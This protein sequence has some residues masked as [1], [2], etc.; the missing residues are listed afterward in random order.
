MLAMQYVFPLADDF[1]MAQVRRR[2]AEKGPLFDDYPGLVQKAFLCNDVKGSIL[3]DEVGNS[4]ATFYLWESADAARAFLLGD[5]FRAVS[6]A[7]GRPRVQSWQVIGHRSCGGAAPAFAVQETESLGREADPGAIATRERAALG[8]ALR[9][10]RPGPGLHSISVAFDPYR[11]ELV[12]FSLW[13]EARDA[14]RAL[15]GN[16]RGWEL[17]YLAGPQARPR[18][19]IALGELGRE[20][21][22]FL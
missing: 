19:A 7:F 14:E 5:A 8:E 20:R 3:G 18:D 4:Y 21:A 6:Q 2:V 15:N 12:R 10:G 17:L 1:D 13:R 22:A 9:P 11:W 16:S